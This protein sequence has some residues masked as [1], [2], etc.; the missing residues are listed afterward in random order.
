VK[1]GESTSPARADSALVT[2]YADVPE[3]VLAELR[4]V[5]LGL[6]DAYEE[7]AWTG[8]R[9]RVRTRTFAH[10]FTLDSEDGPSTAMT[11]RSAGEELDVLRRSGHPFFA[12]GWGA[13]VMGMVLDA[14]TD[15][16]E[17]TELLTESYCLLAPK[18]LTALVDRP[19]SPEATGDGP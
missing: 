13:D 17:V 10:V 1:P 19:P 11:F 4:A 7:Q 12:A 5:C 15:W 18:K 16:T 8:R 6:P 2:E 3:A 14:D 9:W